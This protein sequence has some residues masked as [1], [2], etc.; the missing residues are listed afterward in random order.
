MSFTPYR[1][2]RYLD[3]PEVESLCLSMEE[4]LPEWVEVKR[5]GS[6]LHDQPIWLVCIGKR[7]GGRANRPA[8]WLDGGTHASEWTSV[9][10]AM[11][12]LSS[13]VERLLAQ[14]EATMAWFEANS[15]LVIPCISPDGYHA[16]RQGHPFLRSSLRPP[17]E[18]TVR[19]GLDPRD[20]DGDGHVRWMRWKH[21]AGPY[22]QDEN[23]PLA[24]RPRRIEDDPE[25]A[26][27]VCDEG[28]FLQW[29]GLRWVMASRQ[30]GL[31]LNRNFAADWKP[32]SMFGMD[33]GAYPMDSPE[34]RA[35]I[36]TFKA[37]PFIAAALTF[38]TYT[39]CILTAPYKQD[40]VFDPG[41]LR[42]MQTL[43]A[44]LVE[45]TTYRVFKI[46]P[47]FMYDPK[48]PIVGAWEETM[49]TVFGVLAYTV[50]FWDP[51][52]HCG[53]EMDNPAGFFV[54]PD[55][56]RI[57]PLL[58]EF[59]KEEY[60]PAPWRP[61]EHPQLGAVEIGGIDY[62]RTVRNPPES[63]LAREC[64][65]GLMMAER[66]RRALPKVKATPRVSPVEG[67][68]GLFKVELILENYGYLP[69][70]SLRLGQRLGAC[71]KVSA[72]IATM[73]DGLELV[74]E[75]ITA[76][77]LDHLEGWGAARVSAGS[78]AVYPGLGGSHREV[79]AWLV[80]G[81]G[82]MSLSWVAGRAG[83]GVV[84]VEI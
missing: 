5:V 60:S 39:G 43:A 28:A 61:F 17:A 78:H 45:E 71:P 29:D 3:W 11:Y 32:F 22:V 73:S 82:Q 46:C 51:Y 70:S 66:L 53:V 36:E 49:T 13:W 57:R 1:A 14:D 15:A 16:M 83:R 9:S 64:E 34:A 75:A 30:F 6:S 25:D 7:D 37:H 56:A 18:G 77:A 23:I 52:K 38:H 12:I 42:M 68:D 54:E 59:S 63:L 48:K 76:K 69:T 41:D 24:M 80:R 44:E 55:Y 74:D 4:V 40:D 21:P 33:S 19:A 10:A 27:F 81:S 67:V 79:A 20:M 50:E 8:I 26:Y 2:Q 65:R 58:E 31:D 47:E 62:L 84:T 35:V 72:K